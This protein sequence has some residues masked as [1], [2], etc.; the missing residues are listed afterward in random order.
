[1]GSEDQTKGSGVAAETPPP[2]EVSPRFLADFFRILEKQSI[3][4]SQLLGDL[5]IGRVDEG[6]GLA[7]VDWDDFVEF[8][9][10]LEVHVGGEAGLQAIGASIGEAKPAA[11]LRALAGLT[12][13]ATILYRAAIRWALPRAL[14]MIEAHVVSGSDSRIEIH[15]RVA[16]GLRPCTALFHIATGAV[17]SM[18]GLLELPEAV[19]ETRFESERGGVHFEIA[20]PPSSTWLAQIRRVFR[21]LFSAGSVLQFLEQQQ[22]ELHA[23]HAALQR[24]HEQLSKRDSSHRALTDAAVDVLIEINREGKVVYVSASIENLIGYN[25]AQVTGSH[26]TLWIPRI[27]QDHARNRFK[28]MCDEPPGSLRFREIISLQTAHPLAESSQNESA[29]RNVVGELSVRSY[30]SEDGE[31]RFA[32]IL[33]DVSDRLLGPNPWPNDSAGTKPS[34]IS[35]PKGFEDAPLPEDDLLA[36]EEASHSTQEHPIGDESMVRIINVAVAQSE[37]DSDRPAHSE[38]RKILE[39]LRLDLAQNEKM[40]DVELRFETTRCPDEIAVEAPLLRIA[41]SSL[42]DYV[43]QSAL[44]APLI[45]I[46]AKTERTPENGR[47]LDFRLEAR[48]INAID[49]L[50]ETPPGQASPREEAGLAMAIARDAAHAL[51]GSVM[52]EDPVGPRVR[53]RIPLS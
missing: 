34:E 18:P 20:L 7:T 36:D 53:L 50:R 35:A 28:A 24:A 42:V 12:G 1:M 43:H 19:V 32:C 31:M 4:V 17:R 10:R 23:Q 49:S 41:L 46:S 44:N 6:A 51:C 33:R 9:R 26:F 8:M 14:P 37:L 29:H 2:R 16:A 27:Y 21:T 45:E 25:R 3:P 47:V 22:L 5:P 39:S 11:A 48:A 15:A 30:L 52:I 13:S 40:D 38:T